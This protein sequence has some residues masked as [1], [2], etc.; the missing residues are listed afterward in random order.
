MHRNR[1]QFA[2]VWW[3]P[4]LSL[5]ALGRS[6]FV[7]GSF[8][9][10]ILTLVGCASRTVSEC[11]DLARLERNARL[12][13]FRDVNGAVL[14]SG[15]HLGPPWRVADHLPAWQNLIPVGAWTYQYPKGQVRARLTYGLSCYTQCC[16]AGL[17]PQV[18]AYPVGPFEFFYP[19]GRLRA[20][21]SFTA[22]RR[23]VDTSCQGGDTTTRGIPTADSQAWDES[24]TAIPLDP[25]ALFEELLPFSHF[26]F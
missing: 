25:A 3:F 17:C 18:H 23:H 20:R 11:P 19:S 16:T 15:R 2:S 13:T 9:L 6:F 4:L 21:G 26:G 12:E 8:A 24:G 7:R 5:V 1:R 10:L 22:L 14:A